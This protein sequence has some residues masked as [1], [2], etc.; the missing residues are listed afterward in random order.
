ML[1]VLRSLSPLLRII[2]NSKFQLRNISKSTDELPTG[3]VTKDIILE[4]KLCQKSEVIEKCG[5]WGP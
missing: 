5:L 2:R 3:L 1:N 4:R